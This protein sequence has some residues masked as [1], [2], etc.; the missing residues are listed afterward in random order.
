M[1]LLIGILILHILMMQLMIQIHALMQQ[2]KTQQEL[3]QPHK[4]E[5]MQT[6]HHIMP[7]SISLN[8]PQQVVLVLVVVELNYYHQKQQLEHQ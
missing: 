1:L 5:L 6:S 3:V 7:S 4:Q 8:I 2:V